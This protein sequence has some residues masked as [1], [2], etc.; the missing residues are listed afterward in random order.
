MMPSLSYTKA[1]S[2]IIGCTLHI[3]I[4]QKQ[5]LMPSTATPSALF[6]AR[7]SVAGSRRV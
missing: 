2:L 6:E 5:V 7:D 3:Y 1:A 4:L